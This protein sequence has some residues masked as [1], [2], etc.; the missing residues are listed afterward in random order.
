MMLQFVS[1]QN[2]RKESN[3]LSQNRTRSRTLRVGIVGCGKIADAHVEE[4]RHCADTELVAVCDIEPILAQQL[5]ERYRIANFY[6]DLGK[7]LAKEGMDVVHITTPPQSHYAVAEAAARS[8]SHIVV[9]KPVALNSV[10]TESI[11]SVVTAYG[12]KLTVNYWPNFELCS[13]KLR[14]LVRSEALGDI[15]H[16]ESSVGYDLGGAFGQALMNDANHWVHQLPGK[17]FQNVLDHVLNRVVPF[18]P[19]ERPEVHAFAHRRREAIGDE[20]IDAVLDELRVYI[21]AGGVTAYCTFSAHAKPL[22]NLLRVF[23][24]K[25]SVE[26]N[27]ALRTVQTRLS[28]K[29]PSAIGRLF[30][31]WQQVKVDLSEAMRTLGE[32]RHSRAR[33][34]YGMHCLLT[35]FYGAVRE[36]GEVPIPYSEISSVAQIMDDIHEQVY[37]NRR[38]EAANESSSHRSGRIFGRTDRGQVAGTQCA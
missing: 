2:V 33:Y 10:D 18:L 9:E 19:A 38:Q 12:K 31:P 7:M 16:L 27:L 28:Q 34:F 30:P 25:G 17:L 36:G 11:L 15:V 8:G 14:D 35:G 6:T 37:G 22:E 1:D 21:K 23:G 3:S 24:T 32:F 13:Q 20:R 29:Y 26:L 5:A 4:I